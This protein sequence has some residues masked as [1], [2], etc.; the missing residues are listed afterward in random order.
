MIPKYTVLEVF[1]AAARCKALYNTNGK[2]NKFDVLS[3]CRIAYETSVYKSVDEN[4][5]KTDKAY[6]RHIKDHF[7]EI[8]QTILP[9]IWD[10]QKNEA[11]ICINHHSYSKDTK[12]D[13]FYK[14][15]EQGAYQW[16]KM[17]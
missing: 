12:I 3:F 10:T 15:D 6:K 2:I 16:I 5:S 7:V 4:I 17:T 11:V 8:R 13:I 9:L 1:Q 14:D